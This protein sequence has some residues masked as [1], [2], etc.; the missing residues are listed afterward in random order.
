MADYLNLRN[1]PCVPVIREYIIGWCTL[2]CLEDNK[3][4]TASLESEDGL[5][6][7]KTDIVAGKKV[8]WH[9]VKV[10][11]RLLYQIQL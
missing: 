7:S 5:G 6:L 11:Q 4:Y 3:S 8:I 1:L 2:L 9:G 10:M